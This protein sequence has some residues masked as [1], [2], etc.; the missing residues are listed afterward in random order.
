MGTWGVGR[1]AW[2]VGRGA[3]G[4]GRGAW[5]VGRGARN[6]GRVFWEGEVPSEPLRVGF[7][8]EPRMDRDGE[9]RGMRDE[10]CGTRGTGLRLRW[11]FAFPECGRS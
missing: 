5:G 10:R 11:N 6:E 2:G 4:E 1:G 3:W 9:A 7:V 8:L